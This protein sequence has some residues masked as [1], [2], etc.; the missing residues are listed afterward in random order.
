MEQGVDVF[1]DLIFYNNL[2]S[3]YCNIDLMFSFVANLMK[4]SILNKTN[5]M[6]IFSYDYFELL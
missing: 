6:K 1:E 2:K 4:S 3:K 5:I